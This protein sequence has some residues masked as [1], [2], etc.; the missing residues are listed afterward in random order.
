VI[1]QLRRDA[2]DAAAAVA[3]GLESSRALLERR[4]R[5]EGV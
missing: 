5:E 3:A 1:A 4:G 2:D